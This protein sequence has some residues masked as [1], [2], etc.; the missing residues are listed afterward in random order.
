MTFSVN[1]SG[2]NQPQSTRRDAKVF[3]HNKHFLSSHRGKADA[4]LGVT[5]EVLGTSKVFTFYRKVL[6]GSQRIFTAEFRRE[7]SKN[8]YWAC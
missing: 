1:I 6:E 4:F 7:M 2:K 3:Y 8:G 5:F